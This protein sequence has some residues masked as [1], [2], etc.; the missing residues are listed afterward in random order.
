M[1]W[2]QSVEFK[3][4]L[5]IVV[6][7]ALFGVMSVRI[8]ENVS[9]LGGSKKYWFVVPDAGGLIKNSAVRMAGIKVGTVKDIL[10]YEGS[11]RVEVEIR[12][13]IILTSSA[14]VE[15]R[16]DGI[17]GDKHVEIVNGGVG[18]PPLQAGGRIGS[19]NDQGSL[20]SLIGEVSKLVKSFSGVS[21]KLE[22][23]LTKDG[24]LE[25]PMGR[26]V[27]N[28]EALT[29]NLST[30]VEEKRGKLS[31]IIDQIHGVTK[32]LDGVINDKG[33]DGF[34]AAWKGVVA[35]L[36]R[37]ENTMKNVEEIS[38]K[39]NSGEGTIGRLVN[40]EKTVEELN[41]ALAGVNEYL[42][43]GSRLEMKLDFKTEYL[44]Q[45]GLMKSYVG[46]KIQ[47]GLD[48]YYELQVVDDPK[49][50]K[51]RTDTTTTSSITG[52]PGETTTSES[53]TKVYFNETKFTAL[54]AKNFY[55]WT[56]KG[57]LIESTGGFGV[58]YYLFNKKLKWS[59]DAFNLGSAH[60][61]T[62]LQY[63]FFKGFY[64]VGGGDD[65]ISKDNNFSSYIGAG[66]S[67]TNDDL[68]MFASKLSF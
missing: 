1:S 11:A 60:L 64:V 54:F 32:T 9:Y 35:S 62:F 65:L 66:L 30:L 2:I 47:P 26:I 22:K 48:R 57:G 7:A 50:L 41:T 44:G 45:Q 15:I 24:D 68:K 51:K 55:N 52:T 8:S 39:I 19:V 13:D 29:G 42:D 58:D 23:A 53:Q 17:L 40:D 43:A 6:V 67:L 36:K 25:H 37:V 33:D 59:F 20:D 49:G 28:I 61:R 5:L 46:V 21:E 63:N 18:D 3:V 56:V 27:H 16:S 10:L 12:S 38:A 34:K 31:E 4:G 14:R